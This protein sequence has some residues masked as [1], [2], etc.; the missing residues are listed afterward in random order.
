MSGVVM[1]GICAY[2]RA[3]GQKHVILIGLVSVYRAFDGRFVLGF[4]WTG[5][6]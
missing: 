5:N 6:T 2:V 1:T 3:Y 4:W